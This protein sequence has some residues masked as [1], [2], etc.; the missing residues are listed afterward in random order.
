MKK[1]VPPFFGSLCV[2]ARAQVSVASCS[3]ALGGTLFL[4]AAKNVVSKREY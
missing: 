1:K 2:C 4:S 3:R